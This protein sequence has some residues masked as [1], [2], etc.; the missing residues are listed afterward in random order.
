VGVRHGATGP[1]RAFEGGDGLL[2]VGQV[3]QRLPRVARR[4]AAGSPHQGMG[5]AVAH[6]ELEQ[7]RHRAPGAPSA[8]GAAARGRTGLA[9]EVRWAADVGA[10]AVDVKLVEYPSGGGA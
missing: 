2:A 4:V 9:A 8:P 10:E 7:L 1:G 5:P 3:I 6:L